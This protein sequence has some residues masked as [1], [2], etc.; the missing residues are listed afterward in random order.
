MILLKLVSIDVG[1]GQRVRQGMIICSPGKCLR[2]SI[3]LACVNKLDDGG[4][5]AD[6]ASGKSHSPM[7]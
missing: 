7:S 3:K 4:L 5:F 2:E 1:H 6:D